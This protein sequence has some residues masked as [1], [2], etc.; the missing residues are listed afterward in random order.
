VTPKDDRPYHHGDL[1]RTLLDTTAELVAAVGP[2]S[3]SLREVARRAGVSHAAPA[4]HFGDREGLL[5]A[6]STEGFALL[7]DAMARADAESE[8]LPP[9]ERHVRQGLSYLDFAT[10]H[11]GH[12][13]VMFRTDL[14]TPDA[15]WSEVAGAAYTLLLESATRLCDHLG[16]GD[17][18]DVV[19][20]SWAIVHGL[21]NL[22]I[23]GNFGPLEHRTPEELGGS[24]LRIF[25][26]GLAGSQPR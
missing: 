6:L 13:A 19:A 12:F 21:A 2:S 9:D 4:H 14:F 25:T 15:E 5:R 26:D 11:R 10:H 22:A 7:R 16:R 3:W 17:V 20:G 1:P 8:G 23:A 18:D 24:V